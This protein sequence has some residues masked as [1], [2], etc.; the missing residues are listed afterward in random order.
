VTS[1]GIDHVVISVRDLDRASLAW[2]RL[3]FTLTPRSRDLRRGT[4]ACRIMLPGAHIELAAAVD[5]D[6]GPSAIAFAALP[7][8]DIAA[9]LRHRGLHPDAPSEV[10]RQVELAEGAVLE[11]VERVSLP[12]EE[13]PG[14]AGFFCRHLTPEQMRGPAWLAHANGARGLRSVTVLVEATAPLRDAY[15]KL[16]GAAV[17]MTDEIMTIH[18][19]P[20]RIVFATS[21]DL[22][23]L[24]PEVA[25]DFG[26]RPSGLVA[27]SVTSGDLGPTADHLARW[28]VAHEELAD[29]TLIVPPAEAT[30][31]MLIFSRE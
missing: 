21:E 2:E 14:L 26:R 6:E 16:F 22:A 8:E 4:G 10:M 27:I 7:D 13:T 1:A 23:E 24:Y 17:T 29:G 30:G 31:T 25:L 9:R 18:A 3:G 11:R 15:E 20:Y 12:P 19:G 5:R 28:Q